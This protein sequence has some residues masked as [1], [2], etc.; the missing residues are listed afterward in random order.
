M[1]FTSC[2]CSIIGS[3]AGTSFFGPVAGHGFITHDLDH[4][5]EERRAN[6]PLKHGLV[7]GPIEA[8]PAD[9]SEDRFTRIHKRA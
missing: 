8:V 7:K 4:I 1:L 5:R 9:V 2:P 3:L 6:M